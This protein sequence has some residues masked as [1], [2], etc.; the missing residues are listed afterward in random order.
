MLAHV[1][2][3]TLTLVG[4]SAAGGAPA[5]DRYRAPVFA[6]VAI[7][8]AVVYRTDPE[9]RLDLYEPAGD[10]APRR[11]AIVWVHGGGFSSGDRSSSVTPFPSELAKAGYVVAS[12]DYRLGARSPCVAMAHLSDECR[13]AVDVAVQDAQAAVR[14]L[15]T[16]A[17][18]HRIDPDR[19]AVAGESAGGITAAGVGTRSN[20]AAS[21]VQAWISISGGIDGGAFVDGRDAPGL[22]FSG[23]ADPYI[24]HQ[25]SVDTET[26]MRAAGVRI[27]LVTLEGEGHVPADA[28]DRF[29]RES[30]DFLYDVLA[31]R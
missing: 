9:L 22:L 10:R 24:P 31:L 2:V 23:T 17:T 4:C 13:S 26:A 11:P 1:A 18:D 29:V 8:R 14:W 25:W 6:A 28:L 20:D 12:I 16:H 5:P 21:A 3:V 27:T 19:I 7:E 15:R 30:R